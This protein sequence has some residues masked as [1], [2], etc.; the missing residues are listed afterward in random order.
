MIRQRLEEVESWLAGDKS[1]EKARAASL[2]RSLIDRI[3]I[4]PSSRPHRQGSAEKPTSSPMPAG[5]DAGAGR[6]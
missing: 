3:E 6:L 5:R 2:I 1:V 4:T